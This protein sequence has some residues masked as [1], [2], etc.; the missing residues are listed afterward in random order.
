MANF[1]NDPIPSEMKRTIFIGLLSCF[2]LGF[3]A[4]GQSTDTVN[5]SYVSGFEFSWTYSSYTALFDQ[6]QRPYIYTAN[7]ELGVIT[8]DITDINDPTPID[9]LWQIDFGT[10]K[11]QNLFLD[12][13]LLYVAL[14]GFQGLALQR[15]GL[16]IVDVSNPETP[17]IL[18]QWD[19][20]AY[21]QGAAVVEVA[22]GVAYLGAMEEGVIILDVSDPS[23]ISFMSV[24]TLDDQ[25]PHVPGLFSVPN[26]RGLS[27]K[28]DT[29]I[30]CNDAG[31]LRMV[32]VSDPYNPIEVGKYV[33]WSLDSIAQPAY[34][35]VL[36]VEDYAYVPVD[37]CGLDVVNVADTNMFNVHWHNP[38]ACD[39]TN[40]NGRP[41]HTNQ[42]RRVDDLIFVSG[43]D[44]EVLVYDI[45]DRENPIQVGL[46]ANVGDSIVSWGIDANDQYICLAL[47]DNSL[48]Q[49]PYI[50]DHG[51]IIILEYQSLVGVRPMEVGTF[52][53][54]PNPSTG[55][56]SLNFEES[57][58]REIVILDQVGRNI[59]S[60]RS[61]ASKVQLDISNLPKGLYF[62]QVNGALITLGKLVKN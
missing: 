6:Q 21:M 62:I 32:D 8:F 49:I 19:S 38:W 1:T 16:A 42:V 26:A 41:G 52:E 54:Y 55:L 53:V 30:V 46:Y 3:S 56:V 29:L 36:L 40:W 23:N 9:T 34:N 58:E 35:N 39:P 5:I 47:V 31:G 33:N 13:D 57:M 2:S 24:A 17:T 10:L 48:A 44:S 12:N 25:F 27:I 28:G 60:E 59:L 20:T 7:S 15:A 22:N 4:F 43:A 51:G 61:V 50:S 14:G 45:T 37:Y 18:A 11:P